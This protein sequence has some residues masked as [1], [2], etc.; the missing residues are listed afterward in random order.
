MSGESRLTLLLAFAA[1][2]ALGL[3]ACG[4]GST[5]STGVRTG[6]ASGTAMTPSPQRGSGIITAPSNEEPTKPSD[7]SSKRPEGSSS[8]PRPTAAVKAGAAKQ[9]LEPN[10]DNS[11]PTYGAESSD[12]QRAQAEAALHTYLTARTKGDWRAACAGLGASVQIQLQALTGGTPENHGCAGAYK[13][14]SADAPPKARANVLKGPVLSLRVKGKAAFAL[15]YGP[16]G[17]KYV[18]PMAREGGAWK[19]TQLAPIA[20]PLGSETSG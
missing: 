17:Q 4:G 20:Y 16:H 19:V 10:A 14:L 13:I 18:M 7:S 8:Q 5:T 2:A 11:I 12:S 1:M 15:F 6:T 9:F 3:V